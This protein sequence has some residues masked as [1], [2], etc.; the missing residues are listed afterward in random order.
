M[1][2]LDSTT[3]LFSCSSCKAQESVKILDKGSTFGGSYWHEGPP[4]VSFEVKWS[5]G[6]K[7][8]PEVQSAS[9]RIC[10]TAETVT[11]S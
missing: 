7:T 2:I 11:C 6:G 10:K 5:T 9:C 4:L 3:H 8:E 1:G